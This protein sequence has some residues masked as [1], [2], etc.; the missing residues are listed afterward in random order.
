MT[1]LRKQPDGSWKF[2]RGIN[3]NDAAGRLRYGA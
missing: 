1:I 3:N 2:A